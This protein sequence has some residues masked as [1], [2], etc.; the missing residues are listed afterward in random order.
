[1]S[2]AAHILRQLQRDPRLAWLLGPGSESFDL[3]TAEVAAAQGKDATE[4][5]KAISENLKTEPWIS[6]YD[7]RCR[8]EDAIEENERTRNENR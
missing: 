6:E 3:L 1:M 4:L 2:A 8:I 5:R 7:V